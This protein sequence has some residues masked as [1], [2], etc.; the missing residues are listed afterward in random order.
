[1]N[2]R[3]RVHYAMYA[4]AIKGRVWNG[5]RWVKVDPRE[6]VRATRRALLE[7]ALRFDPEVKEAPDEALAEREV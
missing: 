6:I 2:H 3:T 7:E 5:Q 1:M 4:D